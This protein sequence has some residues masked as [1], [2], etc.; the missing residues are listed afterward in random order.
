MSARSP[1]E[2]VR[3]LIKDLDSE[4]AKGWTP[5]ATRE[6]DIKGLKKDIEFKTS[7]LETVKSDMQVAAKALE[8]KVQRVSFNGKEYSPHDARKVLTR[9]LTAYKGLSREVESK[10]K[11]LAA[12]Q[13]QLD[14][15]KANQDEMRSKKDELTTQVELIEADLK[16]L[17]LAE[18]K[19]NMPVGDHS[20]LDEI[21]ATLAELEKN[22]AI[23]M[24]AMELQNA[25]DRGENVSGTSFQD[26]DDDLIKK[27][28]AI[29]G[30][31]RGGRL[32]R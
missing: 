20:K 12:W 16:V 26:T 9:E 23:K 18:T 6:L 4:I 21:K 31:G 2:R 11:L 25:H 7:K 22:N 19:S 28:K 30:E 8:D 29:T 14:A 32:R 27:I 1:A 3:G 13:K 17:K 15:M 5:I 10:T 24:R